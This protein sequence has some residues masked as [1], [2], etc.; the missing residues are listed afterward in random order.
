MERYPACLLE[1]E[2]GGCRDDPRGMI[3]QGTEKSNWRGRA[4]LSNVLSISVT[5]ANDSTAF[6]HISCRTY[7][8]DVFCS[9]AR[10]GLPATQKIVLPLWK[11]EGMV[12]IAISKQQRF[13]P[14]ARWTTND[15][16]GTGDEPP[17]HNRGGDVI[18]PQLWQRVHPARFRATEGRIRGMRSSGVASGRKLCRKLLMRVPGVEVNAMGSLGS[19]RVRSRVGASRQF[20]PFCR[21][22]SRTLGREFS[23]L[24]RSWL[25]GRQGGGRDSRAV[26]SC[27]SVCSWGKT[28]LCI[29]G[30][31]RIKES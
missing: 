31:S 24:R 1:V 6:G 2:L 3:A 9:T 22:H 8:W 19:V 28:P 25:T 15:E 10:L 11:S 14:N 21:G 17:K 7:C 23:R 27:E 5:G 20:A 29:L 18:C 16:Q 30:A 12:V 4:R 13:P 26:A